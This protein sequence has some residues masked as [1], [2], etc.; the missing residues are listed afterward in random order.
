MSILFSLLQI[1]SNQGEKGK[2]TR[3]KGDSPLSHLRNMSFC[4]TN[5][6]IKNHLR[7][8]KVIS[9]SHERQ[10]DDFLFLLLGG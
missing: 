2:K 6:F 3:K 8:K 5:P 10:A 7:H 4:I 1:Y 9:L